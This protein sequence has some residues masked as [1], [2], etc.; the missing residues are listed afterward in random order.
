M[1]KSLEEARK[2]ALDSIKWFAEKA[3][4]L[5]QEN[6][7]FVVIMLAG[8][9]V[10]GDK[11]S[12][13]QSDGAHRV[14]KGTVIQLLAKL[15]ACYIQDGTFTGKHLMMLVELAMEMAKSRGS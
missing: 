13:I 15:L 10:D 12:C 3:S 2:D 6:N 7:N 4:Q 8:S 14:K 1:N 9:D 11:A 5:V